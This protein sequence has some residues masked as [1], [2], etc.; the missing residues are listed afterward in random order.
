MAKGKKLTPRRL[1]REWALQFLYQ[2]D[3]RQ[4]EFDE[5]DLSLFWEQLQLSPSIPKERDFE[6]GQGYANILIRG[7]IANKENYDET[8]SG[9]SSNWTLDRMPIVDRNLLRIG[10][11]ELLNTDVPAEAVIN[12]AVEISKA[13]GEKDSPSFVNAILDKVHKNK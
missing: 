2:Q 7:V 8:L 6:A 12:E 5:D 9:L 1:A 11:F 4:A 13:F 3:V 10:T